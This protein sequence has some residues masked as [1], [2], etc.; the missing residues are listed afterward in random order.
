MTTAL[1]PQI[2][3]HFFADSEILDTKVATFERGK[4]DAGHEFLRVNNIAIFRSGEFEDSWGEKTNFDQFAIEN[5]IRHFDYLKETR[6]FDR[7]VVRAGH[8]ST[9]TND[10]MKSV[11]GY[12]DDI[13]SELRTAPHDHNQ[14]YYIMADLVIQDKEAIEKV[15]S[16]LYFKRSAEIGPYKD[17]QGS[18][19]YPVML[20]VA[21]VDIPAVEGLDFA[22]E[23]PGMFFNKNVK[24]KEM[25]GSTLPPAPAQ[26]TFKIGGNDTTDFSRVQGYITDIETKKAE[27]EANF[28]SAQAEIGRLTTENTSLREFRETQAKTE[29][30]DFVNSLVQNQKILESAKDDTLSLFETYTDAQFEAAKKA[31]GAMPTAAPLGNHGHQ[32]E[33]DDNN[34][35]AGGS[36]KDDKS[37]ANYQHEVDM[38]TIRTLRRI[39]KA[40]KLIKET[41]AYARLSALDAETLKSVDASFEL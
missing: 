28:A 18:K 2:Q 37:N 30:A 25:S 16:G 23:L 15:E 39:G 4:N 22:S 35:G 13:R 12:I 9:F 11:I 33:G 41:S 14:Y 19:V 17:N 20:G 6:I 5:F 27:A 24:E 36:G 31:Y 34:S 29:R 40:D 8:P 10:R 38:G 7:P 1:N 32:H 26:F 21:Y 3:G